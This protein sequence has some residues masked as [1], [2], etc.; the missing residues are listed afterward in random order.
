MSQFTGSW[1]PGSR[2]SNAEEMEQIALSLPPKE[3]EGGKVGVPRDLFPRLGV[4]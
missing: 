4:G 3:G 1:H 2:A